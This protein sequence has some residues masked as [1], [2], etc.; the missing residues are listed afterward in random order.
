MSQISIPQVAFFPLDEQ[1]KRV[2][3][4]VLVGALLISPESYADDEHHGAI[5]CPDC[6]VLCS[7]SPLKEARRKDLVDAYYFHVRGFESVVCPHRRAVGSGKSQGPGREQKA[8]NLVTFSGWKGFD[9]EDDDDDDD[10][11]TDGKKPKTKARGG[12]AVSQN[13]FELVFG[14]DGTLLNAGKFKTVARLI[15][16]AQRSLDINIQFDGQD[17]TRIGDLLLS[18]EKLQKNSAKYIGKSYLLFGVPTSIKGGSARH[19]FN[20]SSPEHELS[21][22]CDPRIVEQRAWKNY[23]RGHYY[24]FYGKV[25]GSESHSLVKVLEPGQIDRIPMTAQRFFSSLR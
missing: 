13:G 18:I 21:A 3:P 8:I 14:E 7:R 19:F 22:H 4:V 1:P 16:L 17:A 6:G 24:V 20:F 23:E 12:A 15:Y 9:E 2:D 10:F 25:E 5:Y 11:P